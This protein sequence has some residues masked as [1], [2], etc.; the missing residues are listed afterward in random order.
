MNCKLLFV[1]HG[2]TDENLTKKYFGQ[3]MCPLNETGRKQAAALKPKLEGVG[4]YLAF[5]SPL[6]RCLDTA[7]ILLEGSQKPT[8]AEE[9]QEFDFGIFEG[10]GFQEIQREHPEEADL[11]M[12][13]WKNFQIP[14]GEGVPQLYERVKNYLDHV[15]DVY[16]GANLLF[17]THFGVIE[18]ALAYLLHGSIDG[19]WKYEFRNASLQVVNVHNEHHTLSVLNEIGYT[20]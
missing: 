18:A 17:V 9:L 8:I 3:T 6:Q 19:F 14:N 2:Q 7:E 4:S 1:R 5:S 11:W 13:D 12:N 20:D 10:K 16:N 15:M